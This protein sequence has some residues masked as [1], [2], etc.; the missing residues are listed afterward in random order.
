MFETEKRKIKITFLFFIIA[1][2]LIFLRAIKIQLIDRD[3]LNS[4]SQRQFFKE[5]KIF[6]SSNCISGSKKRPKIAQVMLGFSC[7]CWSWLGLSQPFNIWI[8]SCHVYIFINKYSD[9]FQGSCYNV[10]VIK[11]HLISNRDCEINCQIVR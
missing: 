9:K 10:N 1:F 5:S 4:Y 11:T 7:R 2:I 3:M 6:L 8:Y